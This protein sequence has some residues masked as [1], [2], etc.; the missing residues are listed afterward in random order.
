MSLRRVEKPGLS[1]HTFE[2]G[3]GIAF[4]SAVHAKVPVLLHDR[5]AAQVKSGLS[6]M[7]KLLA[8]DVAKCKL[9]QEAANEARDRLT[10]VDELKSFRDAD[11]VVEVRQSPFRSQMV[12]LTFRRVR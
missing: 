8:K 11:M 12:M 4:V 7:D 5:S 1:P 9:S 2:L 6:L 10:V 3:L